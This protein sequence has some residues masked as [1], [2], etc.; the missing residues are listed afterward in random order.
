MSRVNPCAIRIAASSAWRRVGGGLR[1]RPVGI[2][3]ETPSLP[4]YPIAAQLIAG[5]WMNRR[6]FISLLGS[7]A[8]AW[9]L[10]AHAQQPR[11]VPRIGVLLPGTAASFALRTKAFLA[12]AQQANATHRRASSRCCPVPEFGPAFLQE[13]QEINTDQVSGT[14][15]RLIPSFATGQG[16]RAAFANRHPRYQNQRHR[17]PGDLTQREHDSV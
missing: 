5:G 17:R 11:K 15:R 13:G 2:G 3:G 9:P 12:R 1:L 16:R 14:H 4:C 10:A 7:A 8:A 6:E